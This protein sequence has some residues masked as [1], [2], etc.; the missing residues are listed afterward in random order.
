M[1]PARRSDG[2]GRRAERELRDTLRPLT[3]RTSGISLEAVI[4]SINRV[5][6]GFFVYFR[7][8]EKSSL[9][10][11][12]GWIRGRLR[13]LLRKRQ[14]LRGRAKGMDHLCWPN[15]FFSTHGLFSLAGALAKAAHPP[16]G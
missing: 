12:D 4:D 15:A 13:S 2:L 16:R 6:R 3:R 14:R 1:T 8:S 10:G 11:V 5:L 7:E 9:A